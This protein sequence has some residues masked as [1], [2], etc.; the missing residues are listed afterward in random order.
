MVSRVRGPDRLSGAG[1]A[2]GSRRWRPFGALTAPAMTFR[3][4]GQQD[5]GDQ[6]DPHC[7]AGNS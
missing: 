2:S 5:D 1:V 3:L 4:A 7:H 6:A